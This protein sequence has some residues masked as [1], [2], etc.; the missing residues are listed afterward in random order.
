MR[1]R[2]SVQTKWNVK[3]HRNAA[4]CKTQL[5]KQIVLMSP[6]NVLLLVFNT[7]NL[8]SVQFWIVSLSIVVFYDGRMVKVALMN[9][10]ML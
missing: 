1:L 7:R 9:I 4:A 3:S 6:W 10:V 8:T 2:K 5:Y